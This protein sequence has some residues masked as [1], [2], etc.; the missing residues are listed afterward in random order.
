MMPVDSPGEKFAICC[1][2]LPPGVA[3][4]L[5][6]DSEASISGPFSERLEAMGI[7]MNG[8]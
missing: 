6:H 5:S 7:V 2:V 4:D 8:P 1:R 3:A